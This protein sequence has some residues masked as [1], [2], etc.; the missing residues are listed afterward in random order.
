MTAHDDDGDALIYG[1]AGPDAGAFRLHAATGQLTVR[2]SLDYE[3]QSSYSVTVT[4]TDS[5]NA[6]GEADT[7]VDDSIQVTISVLN[8]DEAGVLSL[9]TENNAFEVDREITAALLDPD[10]GET[11]LAWI[12]QHS[13][14]GNEWTAIAAATGAAYTPTDDDADHYLRA[15]ASYADGQGSGKTARAQTPGKVAAVVAANPVPAEP[16]QQQTLTPPQP[17]K[18]LLGSSP[19]IPRDS[20]GR[21]L[22][23]VGESFRLLFVTE[24][25]R[26]GVS[27]DINDYNGL[28]QGTKIGVLQSIK[29]E[30]R[31]LV[32]TATV[33]ARDNTAT[34]YTNTNKGVPIYWISGLDN[35]GDKVTFGAKVAD[36]YANFYDGD[37]DSV[38]GTESGSPVGRETTGIIKATPNQIWTGSDADG[39]KHTKHLGTILHAQCGRVSASSASPISDGA[40]STNSV[41]PFY[42]LSPVLTVDSEPVSPARYTVTPGNRVAAVHWTIPR[43][44]DTLARWQYRYKAGDGEYIAWRNMSGSSINSWNYTVRGLT[45]GTAYTIQI[46]AVDKRGVFGQPSEEQTVTPY[47]LTAPTARTVPADWGLIPEGIKPG[48]SFRLMFITYDRTKAESTHIDT[49]NNF[50]QAQ[51]AQTGSLVAGVGSEFRALMSTATVDARDNTVTTGRGVPIYWVGGEKVADDYADFYDGSWDKPSYG[52][53]QSGREKRWGLVWTGS[54]AN[55]TA[56]G[57]NFASGI[58]GSVAWGTVINPNSRIGGGFMGR[59][60]LNPLY[61]ISPVL[62]VAPANEAPLKQIEVGLSHACALDRSGQVTCWGD[63]ASG[64]VGDW[65]RHRYQFQR[66]ASI[67]AG[68]FLTCGILANGSVSCWGYPEK[69]NG[70]HAETTNEDWTTW[71]E[72]TTQ[73]GYTGWVNTP[74]ASVKFKP[75][76]LSVGNYHAC[77][78]Q[79]TGELSCWGKAGSDRLVI[80]T[81]AT[82][83]NNE[84]IKKDGSGSKITD[85]TMVEAGFANACGIR[86]GG[87]VVCFGR[88][89][90][91]RSAGPSGSGPFVDVTLGVY[92]G[93]ALAADGSVECWGSEGI[94]VLDP[95]KTPPTGVSFA[96]IEMGTEQTYFYACG[97]QTDGEISCWGLSTPKQLTPLAGTWS[98][99][100]VGSGSACALNRA[101]YLGCWGESDEGLFSPP[102]G[103]FKQTDGGHIFSCAI[104]TDGELV[105]WGVDSGQTVSETPSAG[106][107][108]QVAVGASHACAI[109]SDDTVACWGGRYHDGSQLQRVPAAV[110]PSGTYQAISAGPDLTCAIVKASD[111][112]D[113]SL[114]CW[115]AA[116]HSR[117]TEPSGSFT[118]VAVGATHVCAIKSDKTVACWGQALFFDREGDNTADDIHG[119]GHHTS[120]IPPSGSHQY[121]DISAGEGHTCALRSDKK[122]VCWGYHADGRQAVPG[123]AGSDDGFGVHNYIDIATGGLP[124]CAIRESDGSLSCWNNEKSQYLPDASV[125]EMRGFQSLGAG[126]FHMCGI[127]S[128]SSLVCWGAGYVIPFPARFAPP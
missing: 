100:S 73:T 94:A 72:R 20:N 76:S 106:A 112:T 22:F 102:A 38:N 24:R 6:A 42:A 37:W 64:Q 28:V 88:A 31:A 83:N 10:G 11:G 32:S 74:P 53:H 40:C 75:E 19:L 101:G 70:S 13:A 29:G 27:S 95:L 23:K 56:H 43:W 77:A 118:H 120:T 63:D 122:A 96:N 17:R 48:Q 85:W 49:Y 9:L 5:M 66:F 119:K 97:L 92:N 117:Q 110:A 52:Y 57:K 78:I 67:S 54:Y 3:S 127:N 16:Q 109:K 1:L 35:S 123:S 91:G 111:T 128:A 30:L 47:A 68:S 21:I 104:K 86:Q 39:T 44:D 103:A 113:G 45:N 15:T 14:D 98:S 12:W 105:C 26:N 55:G 71:T 2:E 80:P 108:K 79:T 93:C 58:L 60:E 8:V 90:Y 126:R 62:T 84:V 65:G 4:V 34:T 25:T 107:F 116:T 61:A 7:S 89:T 115:G 121:I 69:E 99:I 36:D 50:V 87:S 33:D 82:E 46:R 81:V 125:R 59:E 114:H 41:L 18:V 51:A 124:N